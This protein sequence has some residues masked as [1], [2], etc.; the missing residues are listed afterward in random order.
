MSLRVEIRRNADGMIRTHSMD[1]DFS[2]FWW[3]EGNGCCDC[4]RAMWFS[5]AG[6]DKDREADDCGHDRFDV[7]IKDDA[8]NVLYDE[9]D[10][11]MP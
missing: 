1:I 6:D 5:D 7:R 8:G 11:P 9:F 3:S 4:N 10:G 2:L